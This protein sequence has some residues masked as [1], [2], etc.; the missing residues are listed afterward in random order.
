MADLQLGSI[1]QYDRDML[2]LTLVENPYIP[3]KI[4]N[5][6]LGYPQQLKSLNIFNRP[7]RD[8]YHR[9]L[10]GGEAYGGKTLFGGVLGL[11]FMHIDGFKGLVTR[12]NYDDLTEE[13][14]DSIYGY[15]GDWNEELGSPLKIKHTSPPLIK[16]PE[17]GLLTFRA[18]DHI[19][20]K[21]KTRSKSYQVILNDEAP[22]IDKS[23]LTFQGRSLRQQVEVTIP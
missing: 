6:V 1:T 22:E 3:E 13:S 8:D 14:V 7:I 17:G 4:K 12:K 23:I 21:E 10:I 15:I 16:S 18:F 9:I 11:R 2:N 20:K 19:K 5:G